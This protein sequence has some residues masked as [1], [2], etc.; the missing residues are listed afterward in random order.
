[1]KKTDHPPGLH[2]FGN[3]VDLDCHLQDLKLLLRKTEEIEFPYHEGADGDDT[4]IT[5]D[6]PDFTRK[7]F[8]VTLLIALDDQ[9]RTYC[10]LLKTTTGQKLKWGDL[11]G[12]PLDRF[13]TYSEKACGLGPVCDEPTRQ[14]LQGL[15]EVRNCI[16][17]NNSCLEGFSKPEAVES[18]AK[19]VKGIE[20]QEGRISLNLEACNRCT[21]I[22]L[23]FM[24]KAYHSAL[25]RFPR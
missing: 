24:Q 16:V 3:L 13:V 11:K 15:I 22:V 23:E 12:S 8:I 18:F 25:E 17:H 5:V 21:D 14:L 19:K 4:L 20:I 10:D 7:S 1:M 2:F 9:L 6:F